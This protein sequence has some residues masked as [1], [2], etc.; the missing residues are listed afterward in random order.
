[1]YKKNTRRKSGIGVRQKRNATR[2]G[3]RKSKPTD[4][5]LPKG[6]R[7]F[8]AR[9]ATRDTY[10]RE[11]EIDKILKAHEIER[12]FSVAAMMDAE[13]ARLDD[14]SRRNM[15]EQYAITIDGADA[16]D[17]DDAVYLCK[18]PEGYALSVHIADVSAYV[19]HKSALDREAYSRGTSVYYPNGVVP[20]LPE[21]LCNDLCSLKPNEVRPTLSVDMTFDYYGELIKFD[22]YEAFIKSH[23]RLTYN[24]AEDILNGAHIKDRELETMLFDMRE[25]SKILKRKRSERGAIDFNTAETGF[26]LDDNGEVADLYAKK[27]GESNSIIEEFMLAT[28]EVVAEYM[29]SKEVP[30]VY[31]VHEPPD[32]DKLDAFKTFISA[33]GIN[34]VKQKNISKSLR[35]VI[36]AAKDTKYAGVISEVMIR[37]MQKAKYAAVNLG[38]FG[39]QSKYYCHFTS[40]IRRYPDLVVHR[41]LKAYLNDRLDAKTIERFKTFVNEASYASSEREY[42]ALIA[43]RDIDDLFKAE[44]ASKHIGERFN[45]IISGVT[46]FGIFVELENSVEGLIF[47][48]ML[49]RDKYIFK[50][51]L[52]ALVGRNNVFKLGDEMEVVIESVSEHKYIRMV[53]FT[54]K[55]VTNQKV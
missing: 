35:R 6:E 26:V 5:R 48:E 52:Y 10:D 7:A 11:K 50:Q 13:N 43:E 53:P 25:L 28:N 24:E 33:C 2:L 34:Y 15:T 44:Y 3:G 4:H 8:D 55:D 42:A 47:K 46:E 54:K 38:H 18:V 22:I 32:E 19:K 12:E 27:N 16:K 45:G 39:L 23:A 31:R 17:F 30:C 1:M 41:I 9:R 40:P 49:P 14:I 21:I 51:D 20:M 29:T 37:S 36:D